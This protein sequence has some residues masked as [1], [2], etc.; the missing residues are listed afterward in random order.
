MGVDCRVTLPPSARL[1]WVVKVIGVAAGC[2]IREETSRHS[3][4]TF[5][6][7]DGVR[8]QV[9]S[10]PEMAEIV[11]D[12]QT[13]DGE[14][15]HHVNYHFEGD[16]GDGTHAM[17]PRS[18]AFWIAVMR[19]V[20]DFFGGDLTYSDYEGGIDYRVEP[21]NNSV[22]D[23][24]W[25]VLQDRLRAVKPVTEAEWRACDQYAAYKIDER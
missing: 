21:R 15:D 14:T 5:V 11:I 8:A 24:N 9:T 19:R 7:V 13:V 10:I 20:V 22:S 1:S 6:R 18:T 25:E 3:N 16:D 12:R 17:I 23:E 2:P 4:Y